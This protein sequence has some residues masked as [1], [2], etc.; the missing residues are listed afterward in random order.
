MALPELLRLS[1]EKKLADYCRN[2][3]PLHLA[4]EIRIGYRF[5]GKSVTLFEARPQF[6]DP[7]QWSEIDV[8]QFRYDPVTALWSLYCADRNSRW[9]FYSELNPANNFE[10]LLKEVDEDPTEIFWG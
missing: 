10:K 5:R 8:A 2:K 9:H 7:S 6:I 4:E 1:V 3:V